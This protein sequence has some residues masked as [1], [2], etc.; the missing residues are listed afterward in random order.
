MSDTPVVTRFAPSP[1]GALHIGG[2]RTALFNWLYARGRG[3]KFLLRIEDTDRARSTPANA[4]AILDGLTWLGL[5][6]DGDPISQFERAPRHAEVAR[7]M[8]T[9]G[10]AYKCFSSQEEIE[11]FRENARAAGTSTLFHSP[12]RDVP[13]NQGPAWP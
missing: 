2:A 5:D 1:T 9:S 10:T 13:E 11:A 3:G 8:L 12:W 6:W 4:Q 7:A